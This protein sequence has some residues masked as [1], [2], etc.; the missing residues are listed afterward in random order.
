MEGGRQ[1]PSA[2][3][4]STNLG[5]SLRPP[6]L[7]PGEEGEGDIDGE[8]GEGDAGSPPRSP[9]A[10]SSGRRRGHRIWCRERRREGETGAPMRQGNRRWDME[11]RWDM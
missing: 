8:A 10:P 4:G 3:I 2:A 9:G 1:E 5:P 6:D 7:A 11:R